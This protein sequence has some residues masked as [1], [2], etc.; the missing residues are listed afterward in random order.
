MSQSMFTRPVEGGA[1]IS[2]MIHAAKGTPNSGDFFNASEINMVRDLFDR[3]YA[4]NGYDMVRDLKYRIRE[5]ERSAY[6]LS[7]V[8]PHIDWYNTYDARYFDGPADPTVFNRTVEAG[9]L[10]SWMNATAHADGYADGGE[11]SRIQDFFRSA[12]QEFGYGLIRDLED[13]IYE[14]EITRDALRRIAPGYF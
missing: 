3:A 7:Q 1:A 8:A 5:G 9:A 12:H 4:D 13:R 14:G 2:W 10:V 6:E 11:V